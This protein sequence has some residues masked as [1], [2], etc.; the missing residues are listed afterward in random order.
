MRS[1]HVRCQ[2]P[3]MRM[4]DDRWGAAAGQRRAA[5]GVTGPQMIPCVEIIKVDAAHPGRLILSFWLPPRSP[6][7]KQMPYE[8]VR[9][10]QS[11]MW[12]RQ[13]VDTCGPV[14]SK[15]QNKVT[16]RF[17]KLMTQH[18]DVRRHKCIWFRAVAFRAPF[19][20][21]GARNCNWF[22]ALRTHWQH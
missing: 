7:G 8:I 22:V 10:S 9:N 20:N 1:A 3:P 21:C 15:L 18:L 16:D 5:V 17:E 6:T 4:I 11:Q 13:T 2:Q 19:T 14:Q 12:A